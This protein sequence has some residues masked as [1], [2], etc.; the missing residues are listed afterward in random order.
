MR[1]RIEAFFNRY[2]DPEFDLWRGGRSKA[3]RPVGVWPE[4]RGEVA[5][6]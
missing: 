6:V 2:A 3:G 1:E 5:G 4:E